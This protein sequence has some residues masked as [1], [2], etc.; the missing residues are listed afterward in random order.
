MNTTT[1]FIPR[2]K[3]ANE[4]KGTKTV[5]A[6]CWHPVSRWCGGHGGDSISNGN[7]F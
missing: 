2:I 3:W 7:S 4:C 5:P 1:Q 6:N